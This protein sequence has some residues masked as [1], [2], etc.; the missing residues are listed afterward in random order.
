MHRA[1]PCGGGARLLGR[2][3]RL[4]PQRVRLVHGPL[5]DPRRGGSVRNPNDRRVEC[6]RAVPEVQRR[7]REELQR[8]GA[9]IVVVGHL[10][11]FVGLRVGLPLE[12]LAG[13]RQR[14]LPLGW[15]W[16]VGRPR[17]DRDGDGKGRNEPNDVRFTEPQGRRCRPGRRR[18]GGAPT[19]RQ[20]RRAADRARARGS[21]T[22]RA[23]LGRP[24]CQ[25]PARSGR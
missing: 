1:G 23:P 17:D 20:A 24:S 2:P 4:P 13:H 25:R 10:R 8:F 12:G 14:L 22:R 3:P 19:P 15:V 16:R 5:P 7:N 11:E 6:T 18:A 9:T 21:S